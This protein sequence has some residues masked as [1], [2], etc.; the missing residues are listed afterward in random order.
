MR[1]KKILNRNKKI[2]KSKKVSKSKKISKKL[3]GGAASN[4]RTQ[5]TQLVP[6]ETLLGVM[7]PYIQKSYPPFPSKRIPITN[8]FTPKDATKMGRFS[9]NENSCWLDSSIF[10]LMTT[11]N[12]VIINNL[13]NSE[14]FEDCKVLAPLDSK[15][16]RHIK[17]LLQ[18]N[19]TLAH[20]VIMRGLE[21]RMVLNYLRYIF[22]CCYA[23]SKYNDYRSH[24]EGSAADE[25]INHLFEIF[26]LPVNNHLVKETNTYH[27]LNQPGIFELDE[28]IIGLEIREGIKHASEK[29]I[30][31]QDAR[32][33][34]VGDKEYNP[35][36]NQKKITYKGQ[37]VIIKVQ[38][39]GQS[40][41]FI[42]PYR[43]KKAKD[44][45]NVPCI[46]P[47][48]R[49]LAEKQ[50]LSNILFDKLISTST[51]HVVYQDDDDPRIYITN[52]SASFTKIITNSSFIYIHSQ[53]AYPDPRVFKLQDNIII[54]DDRL[55]HPN[56][57]NTR[58]EP[59]EMELQ[60]VIVRTGTSLS[61]T[62]FMVYFRYEDN[63]YKYNDEGGGRIDFIGPYERLILLDEVLKN[64][65]TFLYQFR[66]IQLKSIEVSR[67]SLAPRN[68]RGS[69][70]QAPGGRA[71]PKTNP[72]TQ[73]S[74]EKQK[75][76]SQAQKLGAG[77]EMGPLK[78]LPTATLRDIV[79][80]LQSTPKSTP[81]KK[82]TKP[83][84][85]R[86]NLLR[87]AKE[88]GLDRKIT[89]LDKLPI[90]ILRAKI[91]SVIS[92]RNEKLARELGEKELAAAT[93]ATA[94]P[95]GKTKKSSS[96]SIKSWEMVDF[97]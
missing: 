56:F 59:I 6:F 39:P 93:G 5:I 91:N 4:S 32:N 60:A 12:P 10:A 27:A 83:K 55:R 62:H 72:E 23:T 41:G 34:I 65:F 73:I 79:R 16:Q 54:P 95:K 22:S 45:I 19:L 20:N 69:S 24:R 89:I 9:Y 1:T 51:Q 70:A 42:I 17:F 66:G 50:N 57:I 14:Y 68:T 21:K 38:E 63:F 31:L 40:H 92:E 36:I 85:E 86:E 77:T 29:L 67:G 30:Q 35:A 78:D 52:M 81:P 96:S 47:E 7:I 88:L 97:P 8:F 28:K 53:R 13:L 43:I 18:S 46:F 26:P 75:L 44:R 64:S 90:S 84:S 82:I 76:I 25:F 94:P 48:I 74:L 11:G 80:N 87:Q 61:S 15:K 71:P 2:S 37:R 3:K 49:V 33:I 58:E